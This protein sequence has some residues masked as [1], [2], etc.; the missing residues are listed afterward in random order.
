[1]ARYCDY[2]DAQIPS[3]SG[4]FDP[5]VFGDFVFDFFGK[6]VV[7]A[8]GADARGLD[9]NDG[10]RGGD[11]YA[12]PDEGGKGESGE[13]ADLED[14]G[15]LRLEVVNDRKGEQEDEGGEGGESDKSEVD[16][17]VK[18]ATGAA[19]LALGE[20]RFVIAAHLG[21]DAGDVIS[22]TGEYVSHDLIDALGL[23][24]AAKT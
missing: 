1:M 19:V 10:S 17:A 23:H 6:F 9:G 8:A 11:S 2:P 5:E 16:G 22:P 3:F 4:D 20:M 21:E 24:S 13:R 14:E 18:A 7:N 15:V 12:E